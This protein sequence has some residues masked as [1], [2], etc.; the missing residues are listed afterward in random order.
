MKLALNWQ[1]I[2]ATALVLLPPALHL[3]KL[4]EPQWYDALVQLAGAV[5]LAVTRSA[6][7]DPGVTLV[8]QGKP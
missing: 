1:H 3:L 2:F 5:W 7:V 4:L 8:N 6:L